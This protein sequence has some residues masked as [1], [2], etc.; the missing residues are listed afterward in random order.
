MGLKQG[1]WHTTL[2][3]EDAVASAVDPATTVPETMVSRLH[4]QI[5]T[6]IETNDCIAY[7]P[8]ANGMLILPGISIADCDFPDMAIGAG[9]MR[10]SATCG[11]DGRGFRATLDIKATYTPDTMKGSIT[12][13]AVSNG[14]R[15]ILKLTSTSSYKGECR[16]KE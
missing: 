1:Q 14:I 7:L 16:L 15:V 3:Y 8:A 10:L 11:A 13:D 12:T 5:G 2:R 9:N 6:S 4:A